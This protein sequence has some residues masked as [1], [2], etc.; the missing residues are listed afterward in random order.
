VLAVG[1]CGGR[2]REHPVRV[3]A[4]GNGDLGDDGLA[5]GEGAGLVEDDRV[6]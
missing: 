1:L 2:Q 5:L 4:I 3:G 6:E